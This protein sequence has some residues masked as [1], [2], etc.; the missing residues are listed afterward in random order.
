[1]FSSGT[2]AYTQN[3]IDDARKSVVVVFAM[4]DNASL[5]GWGSG[6]VV[7][8]TD[9]IQFVATAWHVVDP[10][11]Y[12]L[13][14]IHVFLW[15]SADDY[16]PVSVYHKLPETDIALLQISPAHLLYGYDPAPLATR[17]TVSAGD[18]V[19][20]LG[21]PEADIS[22]FY[23][24]YYTD[25]TV[26]KGI[27][28]KETTW[29]GTGVYQTDAA[30]NKGN[31]GGPLI[32]DQGHIIGINTFTMLDTAGINGSVQ[33]DYLI[34]VLT[35]RG[36][37]FKLADTVDA[38][39]KT[40]TDLEEDEEDEELDFLLIGGVGVSALLLALI[41]VAVL[42]SGKKKKA[43][44]APIAPSVSR[45]VMPPRI[46]TGAVTMA[47]NSHI[48]GATMSKPEPPAPAGVTMAKET[49]PR[50]VVKG[51]SGQFVGQIIE[52]ID[53]SLIIG[54]DPRLAQLVYPQGVE[55]ISRKHCK[56]SY[57]KN[58]QK[59]AI[60]DSSSN[61]TFLSSNQKLE[62]GKPYTL[63]QGD[64]FYLVDP[65]EVFEVRLEK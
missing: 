55:E 7:G 61:G 20:A 32:N 46:D 14:N 49:P 47:K 13:Q 58:S 44:K 65:K 63:N 57:D 48:E 3:F 10:S 4:D 50:P 31:S 12:R 9:P 39:L 42:K 40:E 19:Y 37:P 25:V 53:D 22:D 8:V 35:R 36:I 6:F 18:D 24:S 30:I 45:P 2:P 1:M 11:S 34:D 23:S 51:I 41:L 27:I 62:P 60:E 28:S 16:I 17:D 29:G 33:V 38:K 52:L 15:I 59:F 21:F 43:P 64:R 26:T 5:L 56:V 54:R